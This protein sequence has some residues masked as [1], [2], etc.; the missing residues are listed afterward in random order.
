L[1]SPVLAAE[2]DGIP[3]AAVRFKPFQ[4]GVDSRI[5]GGKGLPFISSSPFRSDQFAENLDCSAKSCI[6]MDF[7]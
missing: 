4:S 2:L 7:N 6:I 5:E 1:G 3:E